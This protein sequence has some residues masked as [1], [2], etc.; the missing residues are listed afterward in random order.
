[1]INI[2]KTELFAISKYAV[3]SI[4]GL[5]FYFNKQQFYIFYFSDGD[6]EP[7]DTEV[8][9]KYPTPS[10]LSIFKDT[11]AISPR[12]SEERDLV[13]TKDTSLEHQK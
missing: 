7:P 4:T 8:P 6:N 10:S 5:S 2:I 11:I 1:M 3:V 13:A 12:E 9:S